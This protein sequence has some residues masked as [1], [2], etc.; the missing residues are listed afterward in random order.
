ML[1]VWSLQTCRATME[2][3]GCYWRFDGGYKW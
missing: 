1:P 3:I 2:E